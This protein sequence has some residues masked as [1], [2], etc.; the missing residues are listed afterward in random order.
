[1]C[2]KRAYLWRSE[3]GRRLYEMM[4]DAAEQTAFA[5]L[6][7]VQELTEAE[8]RQLFQRWAAGRLPRES[9][10]RYLGRVGWLLTGPVEEPEDEDDTQL[11]SNVAFND[12]CMEAGA[13]FVP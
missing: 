13:G 2:A 5:R 6:L 3:F 9:L 1:M 4:T 11:L 10:I 12:L 8:L 7:A